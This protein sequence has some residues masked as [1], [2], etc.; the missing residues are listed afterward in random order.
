MVMTDSLWQRNKS[1]AGSNIPLGNEFEPNMSSLPKS[2]QQQLDWNRILG[3]NVDVKDEEEFKNAVVAL[4]HSDA[5]KRVKASS[6][7]KDA[8]VAEMAYQT[9]RNAS[10]ASNYETLTKEEKEMHAKFNE[11]YLEA[12]KEYEAE[13]GKLP[14]MPLTYNLSS[15]TG[16]Y[17]LLA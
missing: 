1:G 12:L 6:L 8:L 14:A 9:S 2:L 17:N 4:A 16:L 7:G 15:Y 3:K 11:I 13:H 10:I 5:E